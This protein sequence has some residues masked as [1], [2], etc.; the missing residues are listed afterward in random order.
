MIAFL[1]AA[2]LAVE[3]P[4]PTHDEAF[5]ASVL[6]SAPG[7]PIECPPAWEFPAKSLAI[8]VVAVRW[9]IMDP[10]EGRYTLAVSSD[11]PRDIDLLRRRRLD[12]ADAPRLEDAERFPSRERL[13]E[14]CSFNRKFRK[15]VEE[16]WEL[17]IDR[18]PYYEE[19]MRE[20]DYHYLLIDRIRDYRCEFYYSS[21]RRNAAKSYRE[22][23]GESVWYSGGIPPAWP[24]W[25]FNELR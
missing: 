5:A 22:L 7:S 18:R 24:E 15:H 1:V 4:E 25:R 6:L 19:V 13:N 10:R 11:W 3:L 12:L 14:L 23:V 2:A 21:V 9:E 8:K 16:L 17:E 20:C